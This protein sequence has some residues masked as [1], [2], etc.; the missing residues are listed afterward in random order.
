MTANPQM[1][2]QTAYQHVF[3]NLS[4][5]SYTLFVS[6]PKRKLLERYWTAVQYGCEISCAALW[7]IVC[8]HEFSL[9][10]RN[11]EEKSPFVQTN[12]RS[13]CHE[14]SCEL[15]RN[16]YRKITGTRKKFAHFACI[17][18]AQYCIYAKGKSRFHKYMEYCCE[19][20]LSI[21]Y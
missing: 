3:T 1:F 19:R 4:L 12:Y 17:T 16:F 21:A 13:I 11:F 20:K 2:L 14:I 6:V 8:T 15:S 5:V 18:F 10:E 9:A 7:F